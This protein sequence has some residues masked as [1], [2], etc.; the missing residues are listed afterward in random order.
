[1]SDTL[2]PL[3]EAQND[4]RS[5]GRAGFHAPYGPAYTADQMRSYAAAAL[6]AAV[7][8]PVA[9]GFKMVPL[10]PTREMIDNVAAFG[11]DDLSVVYRAMLAAT[12]APGD[13]Q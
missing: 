11:R 13:S 12:P 8:E 2:P 9:A 1:M 6:A 7:A 3:P 5:S 4:N 10:E